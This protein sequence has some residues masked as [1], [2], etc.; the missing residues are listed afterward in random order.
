MQRF[1]IAILA[2]LTLLLSGCGYNTFQQKDEAVKAAHS[3]ILNVY[4]KRADLVP[5]LVAVVKGYA[6]QEQ[7][8]FIEV[9]NARAKVGQ[10]TLPR[11]ATPVEAKAFV[12]SQNQLVGSV[13]RLIAVAEN[14]PQLKSDAGFRALQK[15]LSDIETQAAAARSRY[16]RTVR[17]YNI[18]TRSFPTN[19][20]AMLFGYKEK[21]QLQ[22][23]NEM[24]LKKVPE[25]KF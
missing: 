7:A 22:F 19:L 18:V 3:G 1:Q 23:E 16:V 11:D 10:V 5:N 20:T 4:Q 21:P 8:V 14:Y 9:A 25:V 12:D 2:C 17:E 13:S 24:G 15:Q 6:T